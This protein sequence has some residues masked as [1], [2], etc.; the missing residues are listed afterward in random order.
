N[1]KG[2]GRR[3]ADDALGGARQKRGVLR[4]VPLR[5]DLSGRTENQSTL[6]E[7]DGLGWLEPRPHRRLRKFTSSFV[8]EALPSFVYR[9]LHYD[10]L[11]LGRTTSRGGPKVRAVCGKVN[12]DRP[13]ASRV[14]FSA[15]LEHFM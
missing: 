8:E 7:R 4:L 6:V 12:L 11:I 1:A 2:D 10:F 5:V 3:T 9:L 15:L 13:V 14:T